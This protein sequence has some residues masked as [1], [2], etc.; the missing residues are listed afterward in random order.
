MLCRL[1][2]S[3]TIKC[4]V[5]L[6]GIINSCDALANFLIQKINNEYLIKEVRG[7]AACTNATA[8]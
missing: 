8:N 2:S 5:Q 1:C 3:G 7:D 6:N 4:V